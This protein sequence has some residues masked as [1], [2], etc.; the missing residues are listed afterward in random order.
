MRFV[1]ISDTHGQ[2]ASL[3]LPDADVL[4]HAGDVSKR[5]TEQQIKEFLEWFTSLNYRYKILI[6]GNHDFYLEKVSAEQLADLIPKN[7]VYLN[8]SGIEINGIKIWGSPVQP[9]FHDWAF[10]R[11]RGADIKRHWDLIPSDTDILVTHGPVRGIL[12]RTVYG[13][14]VG[15]VDLLDAVRRINPSIHICGH[16]HESYGEIYSGETKFINASVLNEDYFLVNSPIEFEF[17]K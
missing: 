11:Q 4:I 17:K 14:D 15:C 3:S 8:E 6:A 9:W 5:G 12:D 1:A 10:N 2:H 7:V 16:I 13:Q